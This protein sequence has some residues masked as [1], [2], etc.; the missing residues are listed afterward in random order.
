MSISAHCI[1][2]REEFPETGEKTIYVDRK[3]S[4]AH[5]ELESCFGHL[6]KKIF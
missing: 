1:I 6:S 3:N 4:Q 5:G 2:G